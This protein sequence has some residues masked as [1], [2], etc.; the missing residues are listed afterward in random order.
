MLHGK[1]KKDWGGNGED[2][3]EQGDQ[4]KLGDMRI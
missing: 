2:M 3:K 4:K 1:F